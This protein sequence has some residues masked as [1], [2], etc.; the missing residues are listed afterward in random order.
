MSKNVVASS[1]S[2]NY[3]G[4]EMMQSFDMVKTTA[5]TP[6]AQDSAG[7]SGDND[8][9]QTNVQVEGVDELLFIRR[10]AVGAGIVGEH[11]LADVVRSVS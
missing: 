4:G 2:Y 10:R 5:A 8:Y 9:S 6:M 3:R 11:V 1:N 7:G